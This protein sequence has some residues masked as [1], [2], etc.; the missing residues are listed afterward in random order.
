MTTETRSLKA[1]GESVRSG[2]ISRTSFWPA[3]RGRTKPP[4]DDQVSMLLTS[5][6]SAICVPRPQAATPSPRPHNAQGRTEP[7]FERKGIARN[8]RGD[9]LPPGYHTHTLQGRD[10]LIGSQTRILW[11]VPITRHEGGLGDFQ[12]HQ[13]AKR[14]RRPQERPA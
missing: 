12:G 1:R 8:R 9:N 10:V 3:D 5:P 6:P 14:E 2:W 13:L 7:I 4:P 11:K